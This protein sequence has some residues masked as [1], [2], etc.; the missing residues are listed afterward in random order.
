MICIPKVIFIDMKKM[1]KHLRI[2][3]TEQQFKNLA[4]LL[5]EE[6]RNKSEVIREAINTYLVGNHSR[7]E[8]H[9]ER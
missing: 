4:D 9:K 6:Q 3:I 7:N 8:I 5:I 2:R 1:T